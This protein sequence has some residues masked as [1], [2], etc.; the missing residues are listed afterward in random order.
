MTGPTETELSVQGESLQQ[1]YSQY[2]KG[3]F[4]VNRRYQRKLVWSVE[5]KE[6]LVDSVLERLPIPLILLAETV[7]EEAARL[8]VID[9]LQRLNA[10]FAFIENEFPI[11]GKYF[12]LETLADTKYLKD[13][14]K[15]TQREPMLDRGQCRDF[16]NYLLPVSTYRSASE[17][18]VDEVFRRINSSGRHLSLQE[19]RQAGATVEI[20]NLVRKI[21]AA[22]RGDASLTDYVKL[23]DMPK[24][25]ITNRQLEYG[26]YDAEI[27]WVKQGILSRDAVRESRDE[28]LVLDIL[29]DLILQPLAS[30]GSE[31]RNAAYGDDRAGG[32]TSAAIVHTR[33]L[34]LGPKE[35]ERRFMEV[36]DLFKETLDVAD[37]PYATW[38]VTQQ[39]PRGVPRHFHALFVAV[40]QLVHDENLV[41]KS[42][43]EFADA[44]K[45]FWDRDLSIP[46]GGNWGGERKSQLINAVKGLL[47]PHFTRTTDRHSLQLQ[48]HALRFESTLRMAL[49]EEALF[50][51]KQ[52]FCR[53]NNAGMFDDA[54]FEKVLRT[55]SAMANTRPSSSGL[56]FFGVADDLKDA[57]AVENFSKVQATRLDRFYITGTQHELEA[58]K[59]SVDEHF[60]W[61]INRIKNSKLQPEF[62]DALAATLSPF[63][64]RNYLLWKLE[65]KPGRSPVTHDGKFY[66]RRGPSTELV[67]GPNA[68][69]ELVRRFP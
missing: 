29:L 50:E 48:E 10:I 15:L 1:L 59:R 44:L 43:N 46:G 40:A 9:G 52:G 67:E 68:L 28:E 41:P 61:L 65:P 5:E 32:A 25:S 23:E 63:R 38:T 66:E 58:L 22:V 37:S 51:L 14:T 42:R 6:K 39:N 64:Y 19:I 7:H 49:T 57:K 18:S 47:R 26:I 17:S 45:G 13:H 21:S 30:S 2:T 55:A 31:Y 24:I 53:L 8:E 62:A 54:S 69:I 11:D 34:T 27:F 33:L 12:D 36:L 60:R 20:A 3:R 16:A 4:L 56:I 35:V